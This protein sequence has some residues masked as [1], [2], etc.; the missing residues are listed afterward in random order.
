[1][2]AE[3]RTRRLD[4]AVAALAERQH[5]VVAWVQLARLGMSRNEL[6]TRVAGGRLHRIHRGV[7]AIVGRRLLSIHGHWLAAVL[8]IGDGAALSHRS[9]AALWDLLPASGRAS[10]VV[11]ARR[12][13]PRVGIHLHCVRS[14]PTEHV[15]TESEIPCTTVARTI[16]DI[17]AVV[18]PRLLE[19]AIGTAEVLGLYDR[20][21]IEVILNANP[22]RAGSRILRRLSVPTSPRALP[23]ASS[24]SASSR[25]ATTAA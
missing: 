10:E 18:S 19:R 9:A 12:V 5:G 25:C 7:Y 23:E 14:L 2:A 4:L 20:N 15:T 16:V 13:K 1:M 17:A 24:R 3:G 22:R 6:C 8:T 11:V 21:Q